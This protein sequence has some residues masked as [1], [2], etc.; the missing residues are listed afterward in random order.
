M[1]IRCASRW[2]CDGL[3]KSQQHLVIFR[4]YFPV[5]EFTD[6]RVPEATRQTVVNKAPR[7]RRR[8]AP[9]A[10]ATAA[11]SVP[12]PAPAPAAVTPMA[13]PLTVTAPET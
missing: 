1:D 11:P 3:I 6:L 12:A 10:A 13:S 4:R 5:K 9:A 7:A 8:R 2:L